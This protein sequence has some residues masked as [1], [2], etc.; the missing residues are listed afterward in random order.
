MAE[1][2][3]KTVFLSKN[4]EIFLAKK[5]TLLANRFKVTDLTDEAITIKSDVGSRE[6]VIPL[7]EMRA[8]S[9]RR[10]QD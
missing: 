9:T 1:D 2:G 8:L 10:G 6:I 5:G 7:V 4:N 3:Q